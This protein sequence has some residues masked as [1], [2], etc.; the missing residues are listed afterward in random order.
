MME[1]ISK[2]FSGDEPKS[3]HAVFLET[4]VVANLIRIQKEIGW[5]RFRVSPID[6]GGLEWNCNG[7]RTSFVVVVSPLSLSLL[8]LGMPSTDTRSHISTEVIGKGDLATVYNN[9]RR[10]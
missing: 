1:K 8:S 10:Q 9:R 2:T 3:S 5:R 4:Q 6:R 7:I